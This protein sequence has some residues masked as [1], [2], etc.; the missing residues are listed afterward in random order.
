MNKKLYIHPTPKEMYK[1]STKE[2][3]FISYYI[4][5]GISSVSD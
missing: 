5:E 1:Y 2:N 4:W 3:S